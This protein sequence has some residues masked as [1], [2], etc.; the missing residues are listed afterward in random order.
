MLTPPSPTHP[1]FFLNWKESIIICAQKKTS[2]HSV[3]SCVSLQSTNILTPHCLT[4]PFFLLNWKE[5]I[6]RDFCSLDLFLCVFNTACERSCCMRCV[7]CLELPELHWWCYSNSERLLW[8][9][10]DRLSESSKG[11][12]CYCLKSTAVANGNV[13]SSWQSWKACETQSN[14]ISNDDDDDDDDGAASRAHSVSR[15]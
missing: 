7:S 13:E 10:G 6:R 14:W 8:H 11:G 9:C 2:L 3:F 12:K 15:W 4:P 5:Y 1:F